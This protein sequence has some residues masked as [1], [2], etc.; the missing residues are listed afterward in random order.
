MDGRQ[1]E[2]LPELGGTSSVSCQLNFAIEDPGQL[3]DR[4][5]TL[6]LTGAP[7]LPPARIT[8]EGLL[9]FDGD[10]PSIT[11]S[12][13]DA[14]VWFAYIP[15]PELRRGIISVVKPYVSAPSRRWP[16]LR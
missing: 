13:E 11:W 7:D 8:M 9:G 14:S 10:V 12:H 4:L 3:Y 2:I 16:P 1:A 6:N 15:D 5:V